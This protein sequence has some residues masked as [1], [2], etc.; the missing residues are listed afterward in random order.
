MIKTNKIDVNNKK[1]SKAKTN[2]KI[3]VAEKVIITSSYEKEKIQKLNKI[4][5]EIQRPNSHFNKWE[6]YFEKT[7]E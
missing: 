2:P 1:N 6:I 4:C 7:Q 3:C 5:E